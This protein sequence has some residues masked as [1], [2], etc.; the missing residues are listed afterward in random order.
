[1]PKTDIDPKHW[2][3]MVFYYNPENPR[4]FVPKSAGYTI[5]FGR[6]IVWVVIVGVLA[7]VIFAAIANN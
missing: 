2:K 3:L 7:C 6:P 1:M 4:L 5:N